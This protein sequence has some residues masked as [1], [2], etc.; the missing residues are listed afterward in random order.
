VCAQQTPQTQMICGVT[1][2]AYPRQYRLCIIEKVFGAH[3]VHE[4]VSESYF[5]PH[6]QYSEYARSHR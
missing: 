6:R 4:M 1:G 5:V 2:F 3:L